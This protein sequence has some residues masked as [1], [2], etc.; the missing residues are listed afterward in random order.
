M[1]ALAI[2]REEEDEEEDRRLPSL[3]A[4]IPSPP[5]DD[6]FKF[7][8][9]GSDILFEIEHQLKG[10]ICVA[11]KDG[12]AVYEQR[13]DRWVND[14]GI[15]KIL[16]II[17]ACGI[18]KNTFLGNL[19]TEQILFKCKMIKKKLALLLFKKYHD[20]DIKKE[21]RSLLITTVVNTIHSGLSRSEGGRES[22]QISTA[23]QR[24]DI[25]SF[26]DQPK[27]SRFRFPFG[28]RQMPQP[29]RPY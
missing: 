4:H 23:S 8:I 21:M 25:Y 15:S 22:E 3:P 27:Q 16:H 10:E 7:R 1:P 29:P 12:R 14:E 20:Y 11:G 9:D 24:H 5:T 17:Y 13:F 6:F 28:R 18:N 19:Q 2:P 26:Q